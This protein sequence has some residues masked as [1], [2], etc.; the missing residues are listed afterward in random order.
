MKKILD[1]LRSVLAILTA[2]LFAII[3][4]LVVVEIICRTFLGFSLLWS[5]DIIQLVVCWML[6]FEMSAIVYTQ[7]H[8]RVEFIKEKFPAQGQK[9]L[10]VI[11]N[12]M[13]LAFFLMLIPYGITIAQTKMRIGFTT[14]RWPTGY[15]FAALPVFG[16]LSAIFMAYRLYVSI[17]N[18]SGKGEKRNG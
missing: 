7:D 15:Q 9:V 14:L 8:L 10:T 5:M 11:S 1:K 3:F 16:L 18:L 13:E 4:C 2:I 17:R 6:A 12:A